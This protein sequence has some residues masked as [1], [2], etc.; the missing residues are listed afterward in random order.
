LITRLDRLPTKVSGG[1]MSCLEGG[2]GDTFPEFAAF[3]DFLGESMSFFT[4]T[5]VAF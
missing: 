5:G 3:K 4:F 2:A 1:G